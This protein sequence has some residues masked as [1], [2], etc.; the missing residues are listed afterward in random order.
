MKARTPLTL[1]LI[2]ASIVGAAGSAF[3]QETRTDAM[4]RQQSERQQHTSPPEATTFERVLDRLDRWGFISGPPRG[5]YPWAGSIYPGAGFTAGVGVRQPFGDDGAVNV[6]SGYSINGGTI[7]QVNVALPTFTGNRATISVL[8]R[9]LDVPDVK[10]Y[11][12]GNETTK[13]G[14]TRFGY[15]PVTTTARFNFDVTNRFK[16]G[17]EIAYL[18]VTTAAGRTGTSIEERFSPGDTAGLEHSQFGFVNSTVYAAYD[19]RRRLGY[20][21]RGGLIRA[22]F[23]DYR[24]RDHDRYSF[25]SIEAEALQLIP[26]LRANWVIVLRGVATVTDTTESNEIPFFLLPSI[27]G[28]S[29]VRG[30]PD[31]RFRDRNRMVMNAE[32][33]WTPARFM[34][35]ALFY[36]AGKV[37]ARRQDLDFGDL[38]K[39]YGIGMRLIGFAGY[40]FRIEAARSREHRIRFTVSAGGA[41]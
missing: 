6:F 14:Q 38:K 32:L 5:V 2:L 25:R 20:A 27:G 35:M 11:G 18:D 23:D 41:F 13:D 12:T 28:G 33:R 30:Y 9:Y 37:E 24:D 31:F 16:I 7:G 21:G 1:T 17:S 19:S 8:G 34:D 26:V 40:A 36:D 29:S 39:A 3:A 4:R 22:R 10:Y 15:S